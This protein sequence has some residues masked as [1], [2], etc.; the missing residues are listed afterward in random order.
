MKQRDGTD[1]LSLRFGVVI[2]GYM[3]AVS[4]CL[5]TNMSFLNACQRICLVSASVCVSL[6][7]K[8]F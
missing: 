5:C 4:V 1:I 7:C 8:A 6:L 3:V 2:R